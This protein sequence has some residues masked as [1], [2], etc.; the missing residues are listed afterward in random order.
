MF[1][2]DNSRFQISFKNTSC[3]FPNVDSLCFLLSE[4]SSK[5]KRFFL[6]H[7]FFDIGFSH[8][9]YL[10]YFKLPN[11]NDWLYYIACQH[12]IA[13]PIFVWRCRS[14][15]LRSMWKEI[16]NIFLLIRKSLKS[17]IFKIITKRRN[18]EYN[19]ENFK[20]AI[21]HIL[22]IRMDE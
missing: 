4:R 19:L 18:R 3:M 22:L 6:L 2:N 1:H 5:Y 12:I 14:F 11:V 13:F 17:I 8:L 7:P 16:C 20:K 15:C 10:L 21:R 9:R